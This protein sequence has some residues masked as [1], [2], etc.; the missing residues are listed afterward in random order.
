MRAVGGGVTWDFCP[1]CA[2]PGC[3]NSGLWWYQT[4]SIATINFAFNAA[5]AATG[6]LDN[7]NNVVEIE[8]NGLPTAL[9]QYRYTPCAV[10]VLPM[11]FPTGQHLQARFAKD[12]NGQHKIYM[13]SDP[14]GGAMWADVS[15]SWF[16]HIDMRLQISCTYGAE[17]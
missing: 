14:G 4:G 13:M 3:A 9:G 5:S 1:G 11:N 7:D 2:N 16:S 15:A 17:V 8:L 10:F 12:L 6:N